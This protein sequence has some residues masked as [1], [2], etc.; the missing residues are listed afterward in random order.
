[1]LRQSLIEPKILVIVGISNAVAI[2]FAKEENI[3]KKPTVNI[4]GTKVKM[5]INIPSPPTA[6]F[7]IFNP[8]TIEASASPKEPPIIGMKLLERN[9]AVLNPI[10]SA[11]TEIV[12]WIEKIPTKIVT[13]RDNV[14]IITFLIAPVKPVMLKLSLTLPLIESAKKEPVIG[15]N[16]SD[17]M[18]EI[19]CA[20]INIVELY[21][22]EVKIP[23][24][25]AIKPTKTGMKHNIKLLKFLIISEISVTHLI[26]GVIKIPHVQR[27]INA[28]ITFFKFSPHAVVLKLLKMAQRSIIAMQFINIVNGVFKIFDIL[29]A[30]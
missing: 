2:S 20:K 21:V 12:F 18:Y 13:K 29:E 24:D 17:V 16:K 8:P 30:I 15:N 22:I 19:S 4:G 28:P 3:M 9:F 10:E 26:I 25:I 14:K 6:D 7:I 11:L 23:L 5:Q 27:A 1:M